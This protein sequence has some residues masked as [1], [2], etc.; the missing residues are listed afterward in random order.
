MQYFTL[1]QK[2]TT[3]LHYITIY[4]RHRL[5]L[6]CS[7]SDKTGA[8]SCNSCVTY[9]IYLCTP[10]HKKIEVFFEQLQKIICR[11]FLFLFFASFITAFL[12]WHDQHCKSR[13]FFP[14]RSCIMPPVILVQ[15]FSRHICTHS[16][17]LLSLLLFLLQLLL[18]YCRTCLQSSVKE[19]LQFLPCV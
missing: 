14:Q 13:M 16:V 7:F 19:L 1:L 2:T 17:T 12:S 6:R 15:F 18:Q 9:T 4:H 11:Q 8:K 5:K 3:L 10:C